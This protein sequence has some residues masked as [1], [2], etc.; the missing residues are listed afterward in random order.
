[1]VDT[2]SKYTIVEIGKLK[3]GDL[4]SVSKE[5]EDEPYRVSKMR[6]ISQPDFIIGVG[7]ETGVKLGWRKDDLVY[8]KEGRR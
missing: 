1:M 8:V 4:F 5:I 3:P 7:V 2:K 6:L